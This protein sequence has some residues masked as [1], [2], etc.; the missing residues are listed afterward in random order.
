MLLEGIVPVWSPG[1]PIPLNTEYQPIPGI[2]LYLLYY[3][4]YGQQREKQGYQNNKNDSCDVDNYLAS[5][6]RIIIE[7]QEHLASQTVH[8]M[9][10]EWASGVATTQHH[11]K[12][13]SETEKQFTARHAG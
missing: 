6:F 10:K 13:A 8:W 1:I 9:P 3:L 7:L 11:Q 5:Q 12:S 4:V 2:V